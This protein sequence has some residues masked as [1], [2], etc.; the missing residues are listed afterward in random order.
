MAVWIYVGAVIGLWLFAVSADGAF[1]T[2][3][4]R[5]KLGEWWWVKNKNP[6][7]FSIDSKSGWSIKSSL[8]P[9]DTIRYAINFVFGDNK[10]MQKDIHTAIDNLLSQEEINAIIQ[11]VV[12]EKSN[13]LKQKIRK[14]VEDAVKN[15]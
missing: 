4:W 2:L 3:M 6:V 10:N 14:Q 15:L 13:D 8:S 5:F 7:E 12:A 9:M 11:S 1:A